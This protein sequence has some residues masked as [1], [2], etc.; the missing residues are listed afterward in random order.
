MHNQPVDKHSRRL[1][2]LIERLQQADLHGDEVVNIVKALDKPGIDADIKSRFDR[3]RENA[4][5]IR[6]MLAASFFVLFIGI[7]GMIAQANGLPTGT[8]GL[9]AF[10]SSAAL[11]VC[12]IF[13]AIHFHRKA[14]SIELRQ[15]RVLYIL[16]SYRELA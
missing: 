8:I 5:N 16:S 15:D 2:E 7:M 11:L 14:H 10:A 12:C 3:A 1:N 9:S 13:S 6:N 4:L